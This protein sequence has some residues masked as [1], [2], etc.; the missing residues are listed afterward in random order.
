MTGEAAT[1]P[2]VIKWGPIELAPG[3]SRGNGSALMFAS[4]ITI[5]FMIFI[6]IG[7]TFVLNANLGI[8]RQEQGSVTGLLQI[9]NEIA[10]LLLMPIAGIVSD[11]IGRRSVMIFGLLT[12]ALGY[13]LYPLAE[14]VGELV[15]YRAIFA[16]GTAAATG[17]LGTIM[18]DY[19]RNSSRG[20]LIGI[21][22]IMI[23]LGSLF[24]ADT[25][26][27]LPE[28]FK[29]Q[30]FDIIVAGQYT[31]W[32]AAA[33]MSLACVILRMGLKGGTP[34]KPQ[35]RP[36]F[37][38]L[39]KSGFRHGRNP[40][41]AL[42]YG[43]AF[44]GRSDLVILGTFTVLWGTLTALSEGMDT[45]EAV[46]SGT[47]LF[48]IANI[49]ALFWSYIIGMIIDRCNRVTAMAIGAG[50]GAVGFTS[51]IFVE[52]PLEPAAIPFIVLLGIGQV[53]CFSC[54]QALIG[55]E[56]PAK[57]RGAVLGMFGLFGAAGIMIA[58]AVGGWL[59][60]HWMRAGPFVLVGLANTVIVIFAL[61]VR[62]KSPGAMPANL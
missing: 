39:V 18:H 32:I 22:S 13:V 27:R 59:F 33:A 26:R 55:Q 4:F 54:A 10:L 12:M 11:R 36:P 3:I 8:P 23:I 19:P 5:G 9:V 42:A 62:W 29:A 61:L 48:I 35:D 41:V 45:A 38:V 30:G 1:A 43:C 56:A 51:M 58:M 20:K 17:A 47:M 25:F 44:V 14:S 34:A 15:I 21:S 50:L 52:N 2:N 6:N 16:A 31:F 60:D 37:K 24:V 7:N 40:R 46:K 57:E 49:A 53:S 28:M